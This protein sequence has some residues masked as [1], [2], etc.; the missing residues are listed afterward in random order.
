MESLQRNLVLLVCFFYLFQAAKAYFTLYEDEL[1]ARDYRVANGNPMKGLIPNP[2]FWY[3]PDVESIDASMDIYYIPVGEI[4]R[5]DPDIVG[6]ERAF[7]WKYVEDRLKLSG[8]KHR[9]AVLT[10]AV[11]YPGTPLS[12]P[13]HLNRSTNKVEF[14]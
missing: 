13:G 1:G 11:H 10:F 12:M 4:M 5:D 2:E 14:Q 7:D 9:H 6:P 8:E 3:D